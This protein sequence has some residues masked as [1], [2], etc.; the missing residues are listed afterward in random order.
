M[1]QLTYQRRKRSANQLVMISILFVIAL[2]LGVLMA[3]TLRGAGEIVDDPDLKRLLVRLAWTSLVL[4]V[5]AMLLLAWAILRF[6]RERM[7][8]TEE[9][10]TEPRVSAW[11]EAGRRVEVDEFDDPRADPPT[12]PSA[13]S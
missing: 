9:P 7:K 1:D 6:V 4:M 2:G 12:D 8:P 13:E 3:A 11:E 5:G 10:S